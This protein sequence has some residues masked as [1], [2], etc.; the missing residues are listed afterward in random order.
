MIPS[1][2]LCLVSVG[3]GLGLIHGYVVA[4]SFDFDGWVISLCRWFALRM[5]PTRLPVRCKVCLNE[6]RKAALHR[7]YVDMYDH[8]DNLPCLSPAVFRSD[9][10]AHRPGV[11]ASWIDTI[12]G[13]RALVLGFELKLYTLYLSCQHDAAYGGI[14]F[15]L[16][17]VG[18]SCFPC[19]PCPSL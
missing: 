6:H 13:E 14:R 2:S 9:L 8:L 15:S 17:S 12:S 3:V 1:V 11:P 4:F 10:W 7:T 19:I 5:F 16:R 18:S